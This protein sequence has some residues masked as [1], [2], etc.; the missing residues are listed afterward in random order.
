[1]RTQNKKT[2]KRRSL[3]IVPK[4]VPPTQ[5]NPYN[6]VPSILLQGLWLQEAGFIKGKRVTIE[7]SHRCITIKPEKR[8]NEYLLRK[9]SA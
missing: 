3:K 8:V 4:S 9:K 2:Q 1:M 5:S 6:Y 7:V